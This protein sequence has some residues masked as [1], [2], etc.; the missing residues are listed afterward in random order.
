MLIARLIADP[1][2]LETRLDRATA[3]LE[4]E[5]MRV[6]LAQMHDFCGDVLQLSL[7]EGDPATLRALLDEHFARQKDNRKLLWT[8]LVFQLWYDAYVERG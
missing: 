5:G 7:P 8:L 1:A 2:T 4:K 6:A 3:A